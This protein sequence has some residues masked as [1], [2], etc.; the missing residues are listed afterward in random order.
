MYYNFFVINFQNVISADRIPF[1]QSLKS[2][3]VC[4]LGGWKLSR[5]SRAVFGRTARSLEK[6]ILPVGGAIFVTGAWF[7]Q[8]G[9]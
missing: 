3:A 8:S 6:P 1:N 5:F 7:K 4:T 9:N 2:I